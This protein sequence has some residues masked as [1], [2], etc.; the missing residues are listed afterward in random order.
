MSRSGQDPA[1]RWKRLP[2]GLQRLH[3]IDEVAAL[4]QQFVTYGV[5]VAGNVVQPAGLPEL[6]EREVAKVAGH[7][8]DARSRPQNAIATAAALTM[9]LL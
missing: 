1:G 2:A 4:G 8:R 3:L 9:T 6:A 5:V 7:T